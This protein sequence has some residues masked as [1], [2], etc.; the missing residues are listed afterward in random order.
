MGT[1]DKFWDRAA[2]KYSKK[3][4]PDEARYQRKLS[5]TQEFLTQGMHLLEFG[6][7]TGTTAIHHSPYV[8]KIDAIDVSEKMI[9]IGR[10]KA[11]AAGV[12]NIT[13][14]RSTLEAFN[15][16]SSSLDAVLGLNVIHLVP[17]RKELIAEVARV[18]KIG[19][20]FVSS[21]VCLGRSYFRFIKLLV[22]LLKPFGLMPDV[23]MF[24]ENDLVSEI[25]NAGF[26]IERQW[27]YGPKNIEVFIIARKLG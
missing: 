17:N 15:A 14:S 13:F 1:S 16:S 26:S 12:S 25:K 23:F 2:E 5:E 6:C 7:G 9:E 4:V 8:H 3:K 18:L 21:T 22:P 24:S 10:A 19:G 20:I 27:H 11:E